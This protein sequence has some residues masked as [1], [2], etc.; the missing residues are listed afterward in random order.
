[1]RQSRS[2]RGTGTFTAWARALNAIV[3]VPSIA[4]L[5]VGAVVSGSLIKQGVRA[6][7]DA[8]SVRETL[9]PTSHLVA[10]IQEERRL[11]V[12]RISSGRVSASQLELQRRRLDDARTGYIAAMG[13]VAE[14]SVGVRAALAR[15]RDALAGL[16]AIRDQVDKARVR[17]FDVYDFY[18][19]LVEQIGAGIR[20][21]ARSATE[22]E[23]TFDQ[24][25]SYDLFR[26]AEGQSRSHV[27]VRL[28][29][30][31]GLSPQRYRELAHQVGTY[32]EIMDN[33][34]ALLTGAERRTYQ[35]MLGAP[36]WTTLTRGDNAIVA[37]GPGRHRAS[38][39]TGTWQDAAGWMSE[40][41]LA[42]YRSHSQHAAELGAA[43]GSRSLVLSAVGGIGISA[44][45]LIAMVVAR[46]VSR[47]LVRRLTRLREETVALSER[48]LPD[49]LVRLRQ[50]DHID[51]DAQVPWL[52]HGDDHI[53]QLADAFNTAQRYAITA[54]VKEAETRKGVSTVFD[55][56]ARRS[57][58]IVHRQLRLLDEIERAEE[59]PDQ[60]ERLF[61]L[62]HLTTRSRRNAENLIILGGAQPGRRWRIP[63]SLRQI[64][65][66]AVAETEH[67]TRV[68]P[69]EIPDVLMDGAVVADL[70]HVFAELV[71]NGTRFSPPQA[72]V[73]VRGNTAGRSVVVE[74]ED[75][76]L[77]IEHAQRVRYNALLRN[78]PDFSVMALST[79]SRV[80][81]FVV[82]RLAARHGIKVV[83]R[84]STGGGTTA[85]V[86]LPASL[87]TRDD[88][89]RDPP[90]IDS[91][92]AGD[93]APAL[94]PPQATGSVPLDGLTDLSWFGASWRTAPLPR[95]ERIEP[96]GAAAAD[97][98]PGGACSRKAL[99]RRR[100]QANLAPE[101]AGSGARFDWRGDSAPDQPIA[102]EGDPGSDSPDR[103][104][105]LMTSFHQAT[106]RARAESS[107]EPSRE[108]G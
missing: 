65:R 4:I 100:R 33:V 9:E 20:G 13:G 3:I 8:D 35:R 82:A 63:V 89:H 58:A 21:M 94:V 107:D 90:M 48:E 55:N 54:A 28:A 104:R 43:A 102:G 105:A 49:L 103:A 106:Q 81:L 76:G 45:A 25:A 22:A 6:H 11:T 10:A 95:I 52:D 18:G 97:E 77:G 85:V 91:G 72:R 47:R 7:R 87:I 42:L 83:L 67:Y 66:S 92:T 56:I 27:L 86:Q 57:Q 17:P 12:L 19:V 15:F 101:L 108:D 41:L 44:V 68:T 5:L 99:P 2:V 1:M 40:H 53:G 26:S 71:D 32:H 74:I 38:F 30:T 14:H 69:T 88:I 36:E 60:L 39:D 23:I 78:P 98:G 34:A 93:E 64:V 24:L 61:L 50:G 75:Q 29:M 51:V 46:R 31:E 96:V 70:V 16:P 84:E 80:G 62:D 59:D 37:L 79:E 73:E